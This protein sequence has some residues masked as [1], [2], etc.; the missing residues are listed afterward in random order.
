[1]VAKGVAPNRELQF[2]ADKLK[3]LSFVK[4]ALKEQESKLESAKAD[5]MR[6]RGAEEMRQRMDEMK[7]LMRSDI[8]KARGSSPLRHGRQMPE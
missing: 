5:S 3:T 2:V 6:T 4:A 8:D 1:M 7:Q